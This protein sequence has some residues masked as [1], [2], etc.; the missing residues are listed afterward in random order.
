MVP[1]FHHRVLGLQIRSS[2]LA[3]STSVHVAILLAL[4]LSMHAV[5]GSQPP[6]PLAPGGDAM[7]VA[8]LG[9]CT[10]VYIY[11]IKNYKSKTFFFLIHRNVRSITPVS[12]FLTRT[13]QSVR[14]L[15]AF[16]S[17]PLSS[18]I[19]ALWLDVREYHHSTRP[20]KPTAA[21]SARA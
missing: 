8:S 18:S 3:S 9:T 17:S 19:Q 12:T 10:D 11:I 1:S 5:L 2:Q 21:H 6:K 7:P 14:Q 4:L 13:T 20:V 16:N 15:Q